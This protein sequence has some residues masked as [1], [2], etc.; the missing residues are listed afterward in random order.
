MTAA[1]AVAVRPP[2]RLTLA[3]FVLL[4]IIGGGNGVAIRFSNQELPPFWGATLRIAPAALIFAVTMLLLHAPLPRG[5][6]LVGALIYGVFGFGVGYAFIYWALLT[7]GAG[8]AQVVLALIPLLTLMFAIV[9]GLERFRVRALAG[10]LLAL[11]GI[12]VVFGGQAAQPVPLW[13]VVALIAAGICVAE[14]TIVVK[15]FP[16]SHPAALNAVGMASGAVILLAISA[17]AGERWALPTLTNTWI[18]LVFLILVGSVGVFALFVFVVRR[19]TASATSYQFV[20]YPFVTVALS[21]AIANESVTGA[22]LLGG[23]LVLAGVF[24]GAFTGRKASPA[25]QR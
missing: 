21:A 13:P 22:F 17:I 6:G 23:A 5:R 3:A 12:A 7:V 2:D 16:K 20:L 11:A 25:P 14:T 1:A 4:I 10:A 24:V 9:H 18:A 15:W 19:W 8:F